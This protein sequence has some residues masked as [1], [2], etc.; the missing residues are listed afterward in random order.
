MVPE[1]TPNS[2][3]P[4]IIWSLPASLP[5][6]APPRPLLLYASSAHWPF[7]SSICQSYSYLWAFILAVCS[8]CL[9]CSCPKSLWLSILYSFLSSHI[10]HLVPTPSQL[11]PVILFYR[12]P[13]ICHHLKLH[14]CMYC[15]EWKLHKGALCLIYCSFSSAEKGRKEEEGSQCCGKQVP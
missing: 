2:A 5:P 7:S 15:I 13:S 4:H 12:V 3:W 14:V 1:Q 10:I 11:F 8:F 6:H 9:E